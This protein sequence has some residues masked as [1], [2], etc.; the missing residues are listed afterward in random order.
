M[1]GSR[2]TK[3]KTRLTGTIT[4][5]MHGSVSFMGNTGQYIMLANKHESSRP[6]SGQQHYI[7]RPETS[8]QARD[9]SFPSESR[10][11]Q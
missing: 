10:G 1:F 3:C 8:S 6:A 4:T 5:E 2:E 11:P 9:F 7:L